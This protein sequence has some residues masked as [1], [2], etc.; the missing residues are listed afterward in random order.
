MQKYILALMCLLFIVSCG[1]NETTKE[2]MDLVFEGDVIVVKENSPILEHITVQKAELQDFEAEFHTVGTVRSVA[3]KLAEIAPPFAGRVVNSFVKLGQNVSA[4]SPIFEL[5]SSEFYEAIKTYFAAQSANEV[6]QRN[7]NRQKELAA[8]G[9]VSQR[10]LEEAQSEANI[11]LQEFE[12]AKASLQIFNIDVAALQMGQPLRVVS[13]IAGEVVKSSI[14]IGSYVRED[15]EPLAM[16][17]DLSKVWVAAL[18]K[19][20]YFGVI[21]KGDR[22]EVYTDAH[23][24]YLWGTIYYIVPP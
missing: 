4:G 12:Q 14:T 21:E 15:S 23:P 10:D 6:A 11:A 2:A 20:K 7:Y 3:G 13:P 5:G 24:D 22:V 9:V 17:A 16:V 19:E 8:N 1:N 18:V